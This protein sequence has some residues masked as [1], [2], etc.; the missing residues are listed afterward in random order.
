MKNKKND[1]PGCI[2]N[3]MNNINIYCVYIFIFTV[4]KRP[5]SDCHH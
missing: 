3:Q 2:K 1:T 4:P 5:Y